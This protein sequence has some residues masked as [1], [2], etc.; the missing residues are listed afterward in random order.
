M[1]D[2]TTAVYDWQ[3]KPVPEGE[4]DDTV[5]DV[6]E[7]TPHPDDSYTHTVTRSWQDVNEVMNRVPE[8]YLDGAD[9]DRCREGVTIT[10]RLKSMTL[11]EYRR[12]TEDC[13]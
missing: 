1:P 8:L 3:G 7:I 2:A 5:I 9:Q 10:I 6:W 4:T 11:G 13:P 12:I